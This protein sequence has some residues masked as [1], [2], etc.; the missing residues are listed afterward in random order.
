MMKSAA[1][2]LLI[3][4]F[5]P[6]KAED[7]AA[8]L[9]KNTIDCSQ[10]KKIGPNKW[11][12]AGTAIFDLGAVRDIHLTDQPVMPGSFRFG[13]IDVFP[14]LEEKC[15]SAE[16]A[17]DEAA[18]ELPALSMARATADADLD[19]KEKL[20]AQAA[21]SVVSVSPPAIKTEVAK[22]GLENRCEGAKSVYVADVVS[23]AEGGKSLVEIVLDLQQN[24]DRNPGFVMKRLK[25]NEVEWVYRGAM[26]KERLVFAYTERTQIQGGGWYMP[27][28][29]TSFR[30][31]SEALTPSFIKRN[32][33]GTGEAILYIDGLQSLFVTKGS[34]RRFK[35]EGK[36]PSE[37][38]P[39][40][41]YFDRCE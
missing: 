11:I 13:G 37:T 34:A 15:G 10:F 38:L 3:A 40:A 8:T 20:A 24:S 9:P 14:V 22:N 29:A 5:V 21:P 32:R 33:E 6:A 4:S 12:K 36:R 28:S 31:R 39:E 30:Q 7:Y 26:R 19:R 25:N 41:F 27:A 16:A 35:F 23:E 18:T 2:L 17:K 1:F